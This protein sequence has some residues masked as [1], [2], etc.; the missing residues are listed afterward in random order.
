MASGQKN[1][2]GSHRHLVWPSPGTR[3]NKAMSF[4]AHV[5]GV[6]SYACTPLQGERRGEQK[7][8]IPK[9]GKK[10]K[11]SSSK[12]KATRS[13]Q[14]LKKRKKDFRAQKKKN[15]TK[16]GGSEKR[17]GKWTV[18]EQ[19]KRKRWVSLPAAEFGHHRGWGGFEG[20]K[21]ER[22]PRRWR[23]TPERANQMSCNGIKPPAKEKNTGDC[24]GKKG[25]GGPQ[26]KNERRKKGGEGGGATDQGNYSFVPPK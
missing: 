18:S 7:P 26:P 22:E 13:R 16:E 20:G 2:R 5:Q 3:T 10:R 4:R 24:L 12:T 21:S 9:G 23:V 17:E 15:K 19:T 11:A 1:R 8:P 25:R 6:S 14:K